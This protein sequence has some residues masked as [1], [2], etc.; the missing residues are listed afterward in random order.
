MKENFSPREKISISDIY[1]DVQT[2]RRIFNLLI[3]L[4]VGIFIGIFII[5]PTDH[6]LSTFTLFLAL[7][8]VL[9]S[10]RLVRQNRFESAAVILAASLIILNTLFATHGLGIH[11][12]SNLA[13]PAILI[14]ASLIMRRQSLYFLIGLTILS[15]AWLVFGELL[16]LYTIHKLVQSAVGDF[17]SA[18]IIVIITAILVSKLTEYQ[19][20]SFS[21]LQGEVTKR[22]KVEDTLRQREALLEAVTFAAEQFLKTPNWRENIDLALERLGKTIQATHAYMF[23]QHAGPNNERVDSMKYEWT[24]PGYASDLND[25]EFQNTPMNETGFERYNLMLSKGE[26]FAGNTSTFLPAEREHFSSLGIKS[27]LEVPLFVQG[28]WWG[29]IGFDDFEH[30]REWNIAEVD[31]L[32]IAARILEAAIQRE[33]ADSAVHESRRIYR[34][35]IQAAGAV[36]YYWDY[37]EGRYIFIGEQIEKILGY[38]PEEVNLE[39]WHEIVKEIIPLGDAEGFHLEDAPHRTHNE[40]L[41][42]WKSDMRVIAR[43]GE[44]RWLNDS[45]VELFNE[46]ETSYASIGILQD[47]T[48]RKLTEFNLRKHESL[49]EAVAFSAEQFLKAGNWC[50][51]IQ[52]VLERLGREFESSHAY[53]FEKHPNENGEILSSMIYE[54]TAPG[55]ETDLDSPEFK[56]MPAN[57]MGFERLY[58]ILDRGEPL[59]GNASFFTEA[60]KQYLHSINIKS[61][62]EIRVIVNGVHWGTL[63]VDDIVREREWS[64]TE[65]DVIKVAAGVLGTAIERQ[66]NEDTLKHELAERQRAELALRLSEEK[67]SKA[68]HTTPVMMTIEDADMRLIEVNDAFL[69]TLGYKREEMIGHRAAE[70]N[71]IPE[72]RNRDIATQ[73]LREFGLLSGRELDF[74]KKSGEIGTALMSIERIHVNDTQY[75]LTS[76][77]DITERKFA[78]IERE[79]LIASLQAKNAEL[80]TLRETTVIVTST[81]D[82]SEAVQR[83]LK[84]LKR[85][86][87]YDSASV[88]LYTGTTARIMGADGL[89][90][91]VPMDKFYT[92][93]ERQPD[94]Q[95]WTEQLPYVLLEDVQE[96][97]PQFR[98]PPIDYIHGW[99]AIPLR[100]RGNLTGFISLDGSRVG[101]FSHHDAELAVNYAN[102]VSIALENARLFSDLQNELAGRQ[103]L[104][105][106]LESKNNELERFTYT[107]SHDLKSPLVTISGFL[108]YLE[109]DTAAGNIDR[110][111]EDV[112]RIRDAVN[113]M[114]RLL[115]DLL[116]LSRIGRMMNPPVKIPFEELAREAMEIVHG[117]LEAHGAQVHIQ[118]GLP[119]VYGDKPRLVEALQNLLD[120][121][122]KYMGDQNE[123]MIEVGMRMEDGPVFFVKDNG[124]GIAPE[125]HKR[126]FEL[127]TKLDAASEGTGVGLALVK[128]IIEFHGGNIWVESETGKG[129][130]FCFTLPGK[131]EG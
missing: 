126:I 17:F 107:V 68:F 62:L 15:I 8:S 30:D 61:L 89:P 120:N 73:S 63:G 70:F 40:N 104:I 19:V 44:E 102:Q 125:H 28:Q 41:L 26:V 90:P 72:S 114:Q 113:K 38:R 131:G 57:S 23:E 103:K 32:K 97:Y 50:N 9:L 80:E 115:K 3:I 105:T 106:D 66:L 84:Q 112:K 111:R 5:L 82:I 27:I 45:A 71:L 51:K 16:G 18:S 118:P 91:E 83:I 121:A 60:E 77:L 43:N 117:S 116:E 37:R 99:L 52:T 75:T 55:F 34:Q 124:V 93:S 46:S 13:F 64:A 2:I 119:I 65:V 22:S 24:A 123:P 1:G 48:D 76:A 109:K 21:R 78:E 33:E 7:L 98:I 56:N 101:H 35:A 127:F 20:Q 122:A 94:F 110:A 79:K 108:G 47:I 58:E 14:T 85:V 4:L 87:A 42:E 29:T 11:Q 54:W 31:V 128:R 74:C 67:F 59:V 25:P 95:L 100:V 49:L 69:T 129:A 36:P 39:L 6:T 92:V 96:N 81:L 88:W 86:V 53:L 130:T 12:I 10:A